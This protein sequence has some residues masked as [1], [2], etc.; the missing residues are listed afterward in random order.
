MSSRISPR[1]LIEAFL[2]FDG[3]V[4]LSLIYGTADELGLGD[5]PVRLALKRLVAGGEVVQVGRGRAGTLELTELG[6][7]RLSVDRVGVQLALAQ[8]TG[9]APWDGLWRL[10]AIRA[11]ESDRAVRDR[12]RREV[13]GLGAAACSTGLYV[14]PHDITQ[15]LSPGMGKYLVTAET[16]R[17][18]V[19]ECDDPREIAASLW[20]PSPTLQAYQPLADLLDEAPTQGSVIERQL[21]LADALES[22]LRGDPLLPRELRAGEW[23][24]ANLRRRWLDAWTRLHTGSNSVFRGWIAGYE[25]LTERADR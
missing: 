24:P 23:A 25:M 21:R 19:H 14:T 4:D 16:E 20:P 22:A 9:E 15:L 12:F 2:P 11:P 18:T 8:D 3:M 5:Q 6:K 13:V 7:R 17:L 10:L 1:T